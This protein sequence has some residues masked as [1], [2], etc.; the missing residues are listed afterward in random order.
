MGSPSGEVRRVSDELLR[1]IVGGR[2]PHGLRLPSEVELA[3][4]LACGRSTVREALRHLSDLGVVQSRHGSGAFVLD[5]KREGTPALLPAY[6]LAGR[7][8][9]PV[10]DIARELLGLRALLARE[11]VRLS[12]RYAPEG[13]L[14]EPRRLL[15][16]ARALSTNPVAHALNEL[17][18]FRALVVA[19]GIWPAVW[20]ANVFWAP[21]RELYERLAPLV[22]VPPPADFEPTMQQLLELVERRDEAGADALIRPW[23]ERVDAALLAAMERSLAAA[24][25]TLATKEV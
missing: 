4:E 22:G 20:L 23:L 19:S 5:F 18:L 9:M 8:D 12:A 25:T 21:M 15:A 14:V 13:A 17:E 10:G 7:L 16:E 2:Y 3:T 1:R 11:A 6:L 24:S